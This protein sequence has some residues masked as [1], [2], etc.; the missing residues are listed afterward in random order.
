MNDAAAFTALAA[1][2]VTVG[3][4]HTAAP[5]HWVPFAALA[6]ARGWPAGKTARVT[7]A[8]GFGHVTVSAAIGLAGAVFG[9]KMLAAFGERLGAAA[10]LLLIAFGVGYAL[11]GL[12]RAVPPR[13]HGHAHAH[14]D[15]VHDP[16]RTGAWTLFLLFSADP[17][18]AV[19]PLIFAATPLGWLRTLGIVAFYEAATIA[20]MVAF[21]LP[22]RAGARRLRAAWLDRWGDAAAGGMIAAI[23]LTVL[24]LGW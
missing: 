11:W 4:L 16:S 15:H 18:V 20:T 1:A 14:Y 8:C 22:A 19:A 7:I 5:D 12:R 13:V 3:S 24:T 23:G 9:M 21:V 10:P 17:C 6:R 2:A